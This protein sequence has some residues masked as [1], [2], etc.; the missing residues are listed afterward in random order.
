MKLAELSWRKFKKLE[1]EVA[2]IPTGSTEQHGPHAPFMTDSLIAEE[3]ARSSSEETNSLLLPPMKVGVSG[4][5]RNFPGT[6]YLSPETFRKQLEETVLSAH[7][8]GIEKFVVVNGHGG[9]ISSIKEVCKKL[10]HKHGVKALEW[11]WFNA[12]SAREMGHAGAL[13]TSLVQYLREDLINE[14]LNKGADSWGRSFHGTR[15]AYDT[16]KFTRDGV[17]GDPREGSAKK[18]EEIFNKSTEKL[19]SLIRELSEQDK[20]LF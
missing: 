15:I 14:P 5:H 7:E 20:N 9:N 6:L 10:Y 8:S 16:S 3:I 18:G 19:S 11:T 2:L 1:P 4:E 13:E 12:I 17:V